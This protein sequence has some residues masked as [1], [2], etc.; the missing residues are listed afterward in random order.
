MKAI[1]RM[2][3]GIWSLLIDEQSKQVDVSQL[4]HLVGLGLVSYGS[5][6]VYEPAG[7][8]APGLV[9]VWLTMPSRPPFLRR[10]RP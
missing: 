7:Y 3:A 6:L 2:G 8:L 9:L 10:G 1:R 5:W 4:L